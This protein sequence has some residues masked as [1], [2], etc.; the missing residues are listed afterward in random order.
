M[1][2]LLVILPNKEQIQKEAFKKQANQKTQYKMVG[3]NINKSVTILNVNCLTDPIQTKALLKS[4][5][6]SHLGH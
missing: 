1:T 4:L 5:N 3:F 2:L 6:M